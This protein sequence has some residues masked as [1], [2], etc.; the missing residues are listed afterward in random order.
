VETKNEQKEEEPKLV[1][2]GNLIKALEKEGLRVCDIHL[3][4]TEDPSVTAYPDV[5]FSGS[6]V[7]KTFPE[8][9]FL[10]SG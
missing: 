6:V 7:I 4:E 10:L 5:R 1:N 8:K 3:E 9:K 2:F